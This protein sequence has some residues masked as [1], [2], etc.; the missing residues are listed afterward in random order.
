[1]RMATQSCFVPLMIYCTLLYIILIYLYIY[2][3]NPEE[4]EVSITGVK[5]IFLKLRLISMLQKIK[6]RLKGVFFIE[7]KKNS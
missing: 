2:I 4:R 7:G 5:Y 1:M 3:F 6:L